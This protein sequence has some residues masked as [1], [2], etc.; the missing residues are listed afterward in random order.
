MQNILNTTTP[1]QVGKWVD[2]AI[3]D[4]SWLVLVYHEVEAGAEDPTYA[5]TPANLKAELDLIQQKGIAVETV[6]HALNELG[7]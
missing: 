6:E 5:V 1:A 4:K 7:K 3:K 2:Q